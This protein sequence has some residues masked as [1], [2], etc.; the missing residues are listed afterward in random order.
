VASESEL[1]RLR[2]REPLAALAAVGN[3][4]DVEAHSPAEI[5]AAWSRM[6][7]ATRPADG[8]VLFVGSMDYHANIDG[9][10]EF[11]TQIWPRLRQEENENV[12]GAA[13]EFVIVGRNPP[14]EV[15][16]LAKLAG[17][18]VTGTVPDVR[19]Y[20]RAALA[21]VV[22]LRI[23]SGT[24]LKI[25]EAMAAGVPVVSTQLG[26]EGLAVTPGENIL[27][28]ETPEQFVNALRSLA[29]ASP[30]RARLVESA[31]R[32]VAAEYDWPLLGGK[33][34]RAHEDAIRRRRAATK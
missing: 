8:S 28:A 20:Y 4:V 33:L 21:V 22:P 31:R 18:R 10:I 34:F 5:E 32:L 11:A 26:A 12:T 29:S 2:R 24:R 7:P 19:A 6:E 9:A 23:G 14:P 16:S 1:E 27:L 15:T 30:L 17:I 25:L 13:R 3:G